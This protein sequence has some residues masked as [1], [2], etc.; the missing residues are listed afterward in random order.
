[1]EKSAAKVENRNV[2]EIFCF[3]KSVSVRPETS[4][5]GEKRS[6]SRKSY[7]NE[8]SISANVCLVPSEEIGKLEDVKSAEKVEN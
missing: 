4:W 3:D 7:A 8:I 1:M 6:K 2:N 5:L